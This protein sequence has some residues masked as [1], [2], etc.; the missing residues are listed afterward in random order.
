[1]GVAVIS[2]SYC[3]LEAY[4]RQRPAVLKEQKWV[5]QSEICRTHVLPQGGSSCPE[6]ADC[7]SVNLGVQ[8]FRIFQFFKI[9]LKLDFSSGI[10]YQLTQKFTTQHEPYRTRLWTDSGCRPPAGGLPPLDLGGRREGLGTSKA[11]LHSQG[12]AILR[13]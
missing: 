3:K 6:R 12:R 1:M 8:C 9:N 11:S 13:V 2:V 5:D 4:S 10:H 7:V